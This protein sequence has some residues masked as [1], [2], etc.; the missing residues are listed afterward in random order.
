MMCRPAGMLYRLGNAYRLGRQCIRWHPA[1]ETL[2]SRI[3]GER[4]MRRIVLLSLFICCTAAPSLAQQSDEY[5]KAEV[6][7]G[8]SALGEVNAD[9]RA[10]DLGLASN[11]GF[12][13]S[14]TG[15]VNKYLGFKG[16]FST[17]FDTKRAQGVFSQS[18]TTP[19]R[20]TATQD[21]KLDTR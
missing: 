20:P 13:V 21:F 19:P 9:E 5:P 2:T 3:K 4:F 8:L 14:V 17:H 1:A 15:N 6:F 10:V 11:K 12:E 16:D 7:V 18:C